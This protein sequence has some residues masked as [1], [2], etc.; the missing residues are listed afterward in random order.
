LWTRKER[1]ELKNW[2]YYDL[3][4]KRCQA[5]RIYTKN[6]DIHDRGFQPTTISRLGGWR[7]QL[8]QFGRKV[9]NAYPISL[10][11]CVANL[12]IGYGVE[13]SCAASEATIFLFPADPRCC[14][15][16]RERTR[17]VAVDKR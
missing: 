7:R 17:G 5:A 9:T 6:A 2:E 4:F 10:S 16:R 11:I 1:I 3:E 15:A 12:Q 14:G 13:F 8:E